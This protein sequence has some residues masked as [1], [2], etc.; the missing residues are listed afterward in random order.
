[1]KKLLLIGIAAC[2]LTGAINAQTVFNGDGQNNVLGFNL[3]L[4][5]SGTPET[6]A[7][8]YPTFDIVNTLF[9]IHSIIQ[10]DWTGFGV[11]AGLEVFGTVLMIWGFSTWGGGGDAGA[12]F[13]DNF[14]GLGVGILGIVPLAIG[15]IY[16]GFR[17]AKFQKRA[18]GLSEALS[19]NPLK[20]M[21]F[22]VLPTEKSMAVNL[23][24]SV[25]F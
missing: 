3:E 25:S 16:G 18:G 9:G 2:V 7:A 10:K 20:N 17:P 19:D 8:T 22:S 5:Q 6:T 23:G 21:S 11:T 14:V 4:L 15:I 12:S 24:Y 13:I 1:M